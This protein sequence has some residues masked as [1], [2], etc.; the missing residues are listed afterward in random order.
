MRK[1]PVQDRAKARV[2]HML[3]AAEALIAERGVAALSTRALAARADVPI[4]SV[5]QYFAGGEQ[6]V[7]ALSERYFE[8]IRHEVA[9][10]FAA[11]R[12]LADFMQASRES[13]AASWRLTMDNP[14]CRELFYGAQAW[15]IVREADWQ[16]TLVNVEVMVGTLQRLMPAIPARDLTGFCALICGTAGNSAR[17][18]ARFDHLSEP[19]F[20]QFLEMIECRLY[21][22]QR[23]ND[24]LLRR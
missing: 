18:A 15:E 7:A 10:Q 21:A 8:R 13:L 22:L 17:M 20:D 6:I 16:S 3:D 4:G 11:V 23:E 5:Y 24:R 9:E 1:A 14:A 12:S 2:S 19:L